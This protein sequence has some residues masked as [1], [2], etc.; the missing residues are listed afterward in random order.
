VFDQSPVFKAITKGQ[1]LSFKSEQVLYNGKVDKRLA[2][3]VLCWE[4]DNSSEDFYAVVRQTLWEEAEQLIEAAV[5][6]A[7]TD[8]AWDSTEALLVLVE[9]VTGFENALLGLASYGDEV[10][11]WTDRR[12]AFTADGLAALLNRPGNQVALYFDNTQARGGRNELYIKRVANLAAPG[13]LHYTTFD[14]KC[15][16]S[17]STKLHSFSRMSSAVAIASL[18]NSGWYARLFSSYTHSRA[19][20]R[21]TIEKYSFNSDSDFFVKCADGAAGATAAA[22]GAGRATSFIGSSAFGASAI[23]F[24]GPVPSKALGLPMKP[25]PPLSCGK[26]LVPTPPKR[27]DGNP[28]RGCPL[29][30][31]RCSSASCTTRT[32]STSSAPLAGLSTSSTGAFFSTARAIVMHSRWLAVS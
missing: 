9:T 20:F 11:Y 27:I 29:P 17:F 25:Y 32:D 3:H 28:N 21:S 12:V 18:T 4:A 7:G 22:A 14:C 1:E 2:C 13:T 31:N 19:L 8:E 16:S 10:M 23:G 24:G 15:T 30:V 6:A 26:T 5:T